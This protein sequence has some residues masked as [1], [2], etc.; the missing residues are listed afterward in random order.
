MTLSTNFL[1]QQFSTHFISDVKLLLLLLKKYNLYLI[2]NTGCI[3]CIMS[4]LSGWRWAR[5]TSFPTRRNTARRCGSW[6]QPAATGSASMCM[7]VTR[8]PSWTPW[9]GLP[10]SGST[11]GVKVTVVLLLFVAGSEV[12]DSM[13]DCL[14]V[15]RCVFG[16]IPRGGSIE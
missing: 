9:L 13:V 12:C 16:S 2:F 10:L 15:V 11:Q 14:L 4:L 1:N 7:A 8:V 5:S 3:R 6:R